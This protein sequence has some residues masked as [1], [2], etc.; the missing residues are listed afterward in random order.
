MAR[1]IQQIFDGMQARAVS[2]ATDAANQPAIDM[3]NNASKVALW[4]I[5]FYA[6]S[7]SIWTLEKIY[8]LVKIETDDRIGLL[9]PHSARWYAY[10]ASQFQYGYNLVTDADYYDNTALTEAQITASKIVAYAAVVEQTRGI[11]IKA[12]KL[13]NGDLAPLT[14]NELT[15]FT[16]YME[17]IKDAGIKLLITSSVAD[18]LKSTL[19]IYYNAQVLTNNGGRIDGQTATPVQ[20][21]FND[22]LR[23]LT[24]NG[25][26]V[27]QL[28]IDHLQA[29]DGV[30]IVKDDSWQARYGAL[31]FGGI[32]VEYTPD[33]G[34]LRLDT[35]ADLQLTFIPHAVI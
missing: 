31:P 12:A 10:M 29:V 8:D 6:C 18:S 7:F 16:A 33:A 15:A 4:K 34:Y 19:R 2:L 17:E 32:D 13:V 14:A 26:F 27:P 25:L 3:F 5:I 24:F 22:Y 9:K 28:M 21:A 1:T 35:A 23:N 20:D 11:R 30:V